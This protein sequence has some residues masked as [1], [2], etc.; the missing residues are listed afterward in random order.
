MSMSQIY[1]YNKQTIKQ[2]EKIY[3]ATIEKGDKCWIDLEDPSYEEISRINEIF[4]IDKKILKEYFKDSQKSQ[5]HIFKDY[6]LT[7]IMSMNI[8]PFQTV[9]NEPI[10]M[11]FSKNW[12][13]T[14]HS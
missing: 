4:H 12:L 8:L 1:S 6:N 11:F 9:K 10:Y 13:I 14:I 2:K 7:I 3:N 5:T